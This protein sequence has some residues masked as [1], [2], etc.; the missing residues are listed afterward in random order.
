[1]HNGAHASVPGET[2]AEMSILKVIY[3][4]NS[5]AIFFFLHK[6]RTKSP[7][8]PNFG[9]TPMI[10]N[11]Q[12]DQVKNSAGDFTPVPFKTY[13]KQEQTSLKPGTPSV[14]GRPG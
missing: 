13:H 4:F 3:R 10:W 8:R 12:S 11:S 9:R 6:S 7:L 14:A 5:H 2:I 1:M